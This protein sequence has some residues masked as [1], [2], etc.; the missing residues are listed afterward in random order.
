MLNTVQQL[1][2]WGKFRSLNKRYNTLIEQAKG[3]RD[4]DPTLLVEETFWYETA[5][6][7]EK[8]RRLQTSKASLVSISSHLPPP[9]VYPKAMV[10]QGNQA[11]PPYLFNQRPPSAMFIILFTLM[12]GVAIGTGAVWLLIP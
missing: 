6:L 12:G 5:I 8:R 1:I 9:T 4:G 11:D 7:L 10:S 3:N 2:L